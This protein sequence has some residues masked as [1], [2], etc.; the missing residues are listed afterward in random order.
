MLDEITVHGSNPKDKS[1][2]EILAS[3]SK[4]SKDFEKRG[5]N[6]IEEA[7]RSLPGLINQAGYLVWRGAPVGYYIDGTLCL[8]DGRSS[9]Q[10]QTYTSGYS[11]TKRGN[12][13]M[14]QSTSAPIDT[15]GIPSLNE[16]S[17]RVPFTAIERIDFLRPE[18]SLFLERPFPGGVVMITTKSSDDKG[19]VRQYELK[20]FLPLGY[21]EHKE[22]A[23][24]LLASDLNEYEL[25]TQ[26]TVL[27]IP[28]I[29]L[30][31]LSDLRLK[32]KIG[33]DHEVRLEGVSPDGQII[34]TD[35]RQP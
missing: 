2:Y 8:E 16:L 17:S 31:E 14:P 21:Q 11:K 28:S 29:K 18:H 24:P 9:S 13:Y 1:I 19:W 4:T 22:Y 25:E 10:Y 26:P 27:W 7:M 34:F 15:R 3:Y 33:P 32:H 23:S 20:D 5:W 30:S 6:N 12:I 35:S